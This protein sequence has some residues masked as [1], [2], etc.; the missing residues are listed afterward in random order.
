[1][2]INAHN[3]QELHHNGHEYAPMG[4]NWAQIAQ[5][6]AGICTYHAIPW[7]IMAPGGQF[8]VI[9]TIFLTFW[10]KITGFYTLF[11]GFHS[12]GGLK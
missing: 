3:M 6:F 5:Y 8:W 7:P 2:A 9:L 1:M 12:V 11:Y 10:A 4:T